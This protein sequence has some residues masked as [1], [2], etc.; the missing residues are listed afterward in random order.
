[1]I[2]HPLGTETNP[3]LFL[4]TGEGAPSK[5]EGDGGAFWRGSRGNFSLAV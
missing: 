5:S 2:L 4:P 3:R 1:M